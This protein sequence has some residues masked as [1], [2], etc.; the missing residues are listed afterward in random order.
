MPVPTW[1]SPTATSFTRFKD[2]P[3]TLG[4]AVDTLTQDIPTPVLLL[5]PPVHE[6]FERRL[7][8]TSRVMVATDHLT[9]DD[10]LVSWGVRLTKRGG[11]LFLA[12]IEDDATLK[13]Y[14]EIIELIPRID[15]EVARKE[16]PK[17]LLDRPRDYIDSIAAV[18]AEQL[19]VE[20]V[21]PV[22]VMGHAVT[23]YKKLLEEH[24]IDL[25]ILNT[26]DPRQDAMDA[27]AHALAVEVRD[28][29]L[30]LI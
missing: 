21:E 10:R 17:K 6:D 26:K 11:H 9:G 16:I 3:H 5:P 29:P 18:L 25:L 28:R 14:L 20:K 22:V 4:S 7:A 8:G 23:D 19:I 27:M 30:L 2:L 12:H 15:T 1:S 13:R 24:D